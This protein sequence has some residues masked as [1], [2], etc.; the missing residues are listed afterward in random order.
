[1][2]LTVKNL[3]TVIAAAGEAA[4]MAA[5]AL[6]S[7]PRKIIGSLLMAELGLPNFGPTFS[8]TCENH[9]GRGPAAISQWDATAKEWTLVTDF[10]DPDEEVVNKLIMEDSAAFAAENNIAERCN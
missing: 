5:P 4:R 9:G 10:T 8:V 7:S 1:M 6:Y 3:S 2:G